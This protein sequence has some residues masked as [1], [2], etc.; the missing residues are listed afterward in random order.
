MESAER[1]EL[2][3]DIISES[4]QLSNAAEAIDSQSWL[5]VSFRLIAGSRRAAFISALALRN[6]S[7]PASSETKLLRVSDA[8]A[9]EILSK[10]VGVARTARQTSII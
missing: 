5:T 7:N 1:D 10:T 4:P 6:H 8:A 2:K 9:H 3:D